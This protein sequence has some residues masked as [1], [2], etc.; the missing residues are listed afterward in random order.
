MTQVAVCRRTVG[1]SRTPTLRLLDLRGGKEDLDSIAALLVGRLPEPG[2]C[3]RMPG[4]WWWSR[5][6]HRALLIADPMER[7]QFDRSVERSVSDGPDVAVEDLSQAH[8]GIT[9]VGPLAGRLASSPA[10]RPADPVLC[11]ADGEEHRLLV[12]PVARADAACRV[13]L[14]AGRSLGAVLV[15]ARATELHRAARHPIAGAK[16]PTHPPFPGALSR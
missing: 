9:L 5:F 16:P 4:G 11:V 8:E 15:E 3:V 13:L 1:L 10:A 12:L 6:P 2:A 7:A 14:E